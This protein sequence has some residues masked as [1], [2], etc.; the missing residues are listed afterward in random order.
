MHYQCNDRSKIGCKTTSINNMREDIK[1]S[2]LWYY[3]T[4]RTSIYSRLILHMHL[5]GSYLETLLTSNQTQH[6]P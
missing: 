6:Q 5:S 3:K 1:R 4:L 2:T